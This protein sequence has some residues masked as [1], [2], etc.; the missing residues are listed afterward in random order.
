ML[1]F[2][3]N[4]KLYF[5]LIRLRHIGKIRVKQLSPIILNLGNKVES[6]PIFAMIFGSFSLLINI[7]QN[8][9][10][11]KDVNHALYLEKNGRRMIVEVDHLLTK[12]LTTTFVS[13][14][15]QKILNKI[16]FGVVN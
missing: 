9:E 6:N 13:Q 5:L 2:I 16:N 4:I 15:D 12:I 8:L 7:Y 1:K 10:K 14:E 11:A 3:N